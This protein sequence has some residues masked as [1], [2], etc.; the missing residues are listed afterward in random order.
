[1][2]GLR[3]SDRHLWTNLGGRCFVRPPGGRTGITS[4]T[5]K[6][7]K[8]MEVT[9]KTGKVS[10]FRRMITRFLSGKNLE[11]LLKIYQNLN[12]NRKFWQYFCQMVELFSKILT[13]ALVVIFPQPTYRVES[14]LWGWILEDTRISPSL[15][16][17]I[18]LQRSWCIQNGLTRPPGH[19]SGGG[20]SGHTK[21]MGDPLCFW[22]PPESETPSRKTL[23]KRV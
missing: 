4:Y 19:I 3:S 23:R 21:C 7:S 10:H 17:A 11:K 14:I 6:G 2:P 15:M 16:C 9:I 22:I 13:L 12:M 8:L 18:P 5:R 1:M 20:S